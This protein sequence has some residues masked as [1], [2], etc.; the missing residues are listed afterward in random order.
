MR[1]GGV[2]EGDKKPLGQESSS[3]A[4]NVTPGL[5]SPL[6]TENP[7]LPQVRLA[8]AEGQ[9]PRVAGVTLDYLQKLMWENVGIIR[10]AKSLKH[11]LTQ[12]SNW[13]ETFVPAEERS[14]LEL[15]NMIKIGKLMA[16]AALLR[17]ESR[18]CHFRID[19]PVEDP[20]WAKHIILVRGTRARLK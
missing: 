16:Q 11:A 4:T 8:K 5:G 3:Q 1:R 18:G 13:W 9:E 12:L 17:E 6:G 7:K 2:W 10:S 20:K 15:A 19:F 14:A